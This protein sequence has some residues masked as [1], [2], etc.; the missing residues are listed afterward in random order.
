MFCKLV[1]QNKRKL[2]VKKIYTK[3]QIQFFVVALTG[4]K[5]KNKKCSA[6]TAL[7]FTN[8]SLYFTFFKSVL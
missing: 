5:N 7:L 8:Y 2:G 1:F 4:I 6:Q 3:C